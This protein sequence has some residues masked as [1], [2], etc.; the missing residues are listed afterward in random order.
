MTCEH[1]QARVE[2]AARQVAGVSAAQVDLAAGTLTVSGGDPMAIIRA[3]GEAGYPAELEETGEPATCPMPEPGA[4]APQRPD[5]PRPYLLQVEDMHCAS[6]VGRVEAAIRAVEGV[7]EAAVNLVEKSASVVGGD[8]D[9]V[10]AAIVQ[11]GYRASV[12]ADVRSAGEET[13]EIDILGMHCA[14]CVR[15]VE[16]ALLDVPGVTTAAV[17][18][19]EKKALVQGGAPD[20]AVQAILG[21]GYGAAL[22]Q[23]LTS[24]IFFVRLQPQPEAADLEQV[25]QVLLAPDTALQ[26]ELKEGRLRIK[27]TQHP[28]DVL[29]RLADI[30]YQ[31][32]LEESF[33]DP[34]LRQAEETRLEIRRS[35]QRA[36][37]AGLVGFVLMAGHM[38]GLFPHPHEGQLFWAGA[39]LLC[40]FTMVFSGRSYFVGAWKQARHGS[41]NMD[42]LVALGTGA[43]WVSSAL[44]IADP[45]FIPGA[46]NNLYLDASV[47]ILAFLQLGHALETRAKRTTSEAIGAL[48]GLRART[49]WVLRAA[50]QVEIPVSLLRINDRVRVRPGEKVPIDGEIVEGRTTIDE[51]MLTGEPLAVVRQLGDMV[52]GGTMN[53]SGAFVLR[54]TRLGD[55]T[56]LAR[57]IRMVKTA[58]M[59]KPPIGRLVDRIAGVFVPVVIGISLVTFLAWLGFATDLRL[60]HALTAAIAVLVIACPCA[61]GLATPIAIMVGTSRAAQCNVLIRNSDALQTAST[62]THVVVDK[63]GTL[64]DGC[65]AVTAIFPAVGSREREILLWAASLES[66]SEH[67]LAE[68]VLTAQLEQGEPLR[69]LDNFTA[70]PGRGVRAEYADI[71]YLL[72]NRH[73][74]IEEGLA[75]PADLQVEAGRQA[76]QGGTPVWLAQGVKVLGLLIL[77]D[78]VRQDSAAAVKALQAQGITV[79]MCSGDSRATAEAVAREV[80]IAEVHSEI[81]PEEK[82][83]VI[84]SLQQQGFKVGMVGDGVNDAPALAQADTG[85]AVG[86]GTDVAIENA[87][88]T[89]AGD[90]LLLVADAIAIS[91]ATIR[92][93]KQNLFGAFIYNVIGIPLAAGLFY[94]FTGWL[95]EPMFASAAMALSSVTVVTN[96][97]RLRF[98]RPR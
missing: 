21:Q 94:P 93:I 26:M 40:L 74:L 91:S 47:M 57:I 70:I 79:V 12:V 86:S 9:R 90:S 85:F 53:R 97:N 64:T 48:V 1:C 29:L 61:L 32:V 2:E 52:T 37:L 68:A 15:R 6:C 10:A 66:G 36:L 54:V 34:G 98:F 60:A 18:L 95:L 92:N 16:E 4:K 62:L 75:L 72:G 39:A 20:L 77:K 58:Q 33:A 84:Q 30:G 22:R 56:T 89:L 38:S 11:A 49:A 59:S 13:Y 87:D 88:I 19:I 3:V 27:T 76:A 78:P 73:F 43:A 65:P 41:A 71:T 7:R 81:L 46:A 67:P 83:Q 25:R 14:S 28:A 24:D 80:G 44:V 8:P 50:G 5:S 31:V 96:A 23:R 45:N 55:D 82:L 69:S 17:N 35:W 42:T 63:T 51:S